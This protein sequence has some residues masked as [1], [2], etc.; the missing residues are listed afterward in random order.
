MGAVDQVATAAAVTIQE[1]SMYTLQAR[2]AVSGSPVSSTHLGSTK[3]PNKTETKKKDA[4]TSPR[5]A[6]N[7]RHAVRATM[8]YEPGTSNFAG[9]YMHHM[10]LLPV[11]GSGPQEACD[12]KRCRCMQAE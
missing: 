10:A 1:G 11:L 6:C 9:S 12:V 7:A 4:M 5:K 3:Q 2:M 8:G